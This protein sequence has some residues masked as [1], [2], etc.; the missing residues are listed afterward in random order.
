MRYI[1]K[2]I[3]PAIC[4]PEARA[5]KRNTS[6]AWAKF[7]YTDIICRFSCIP[8]FVCDN[9]AE[10]KGAVKQLFDRYG[11]I[12]ILVA[13]YHPEANGIAE[14]SHQTLMNSLLKA[15]GTKDSDWP[16]YLTGAL[17][18]MR[19]TTHRMTGY[20]PYYLLYA[21]NPVF[22]FDLADRTWFALDWY[23]V[24]DTED[25]IALR[26]KQI[27]RREQDVG[28]ALDRL[29][30]ARKR[31]VEDLEKG[32]GPSSKVLDVGTLV[33]VH[34]TWLDGQHGNKGALRWAGPYVVDK[35]MGQFYELRELDGTRM[36]G[37]FAVD[38]VKRFHHREGHQSMKDLPAHRQRLQPTEAD[39]TIGATFIIPRGS[40]F[41]SIVD[42]SRCL[43]IGEIKDET[44][45]FNGTLI[46]DT[47]LKDLEE[48]A[49]KVQ[50]WW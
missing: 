23:A 30:Q 13:P 45:L 9:G 42:G 36:K 28:K 1:L 29:N 33:L 46:A 4:W 6:K 50:P 16:L 2:A 8:I 41:T 32:R 20:T 10:F 25:L 35:V 44:T 3:E 47:N 27:T 48:D 31:A 34:Q 11:L 18:A 43:T 14:R 37:R 40:C 5:A 21:Q 38:R 39:H 26:L 19:T 17:L 49:C 15:C 7:I 24:K 22:G 12:C